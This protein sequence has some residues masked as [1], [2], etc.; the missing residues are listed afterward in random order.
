MLAWNPDRVYVWI[1]HIAM[2]AALFAYRDVPSVALGVA[3]V[4]A[5]TH[6]YKLATSHCSDKEAETSLFHLLFVLPLLYLGRA[7]PR[8]VGAIAVLQAL[9][10][11]GRFALYGT[12]IYAVKR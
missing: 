1:A 10:F 12:C 8:L 2:A 11:V 3:L 4:G 7:N 5:A 9:H 6:A